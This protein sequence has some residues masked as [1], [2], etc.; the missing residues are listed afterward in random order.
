[1][2]AGDGLFGAVLRGVDDFGWADGGDQFREDVE[3]GALDP[4]GGVDDEEGFGVGGFLVV[5]EEV[6]GA[7]D[8]MGW[9]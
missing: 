5:G 9:V 7:F 8:E 6:E 3:A 2:Q 4:A 1:M